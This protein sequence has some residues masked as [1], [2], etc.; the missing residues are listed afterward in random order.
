M[1]NNK[2]IDFFRSV[3]DKDNDLDID[4]DTDTGIC[5]NNDIDIDIDNDIE[6]DIEIGERNSVAD[7]AVAFYD[8]F[9]ALILQKYQGTIVTVVMSF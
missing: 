7:A 5:I 2:Y 3:A 4:V 1:T 9:F 8:N 6:I